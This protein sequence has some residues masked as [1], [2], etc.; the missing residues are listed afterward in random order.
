MADMNKEQQL[1]VKINEPSSYI[2]SQPVLNDDITKT[3]QVPAPS[4]LDSILQEQPVEK[5]EKKKKKKKKGKTGRQKE[6]E[7]LTKE[8]KEIFESPDKLNV[9][10]ERIH[11]L[12]LGQKK[13]LL[14][15]CQLLDKYNYGSLPYEQFRLIIRDRL[16]KLSTEDFFILTK[17]FE[18]G[19]TSIDY[20]AILDE[21]LGN[22]ILRHVTQLPVPLPTEIVLEK[23]SS[24]ESKSIFNEP[25]QVAQPKYVTL[26]LRLITFDA[27]NAYPGHVHITVPDHTS[28]YAL[29]KM[30]IDKTDLATRSISIFREK[31][32]SRHGLLDPMDTLEHHQLTGA[33]IDGTHK[34]LF[35]TYTLYY[36]YSPMELRSDCPILKCDYYMK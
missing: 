12:L 10:C 19:G 26:H 34:Q 6:I 4:F 25:L 30:V 1:Q 35:P 16:P 7:R 33:C 32:R 28:V 11:S 2:V 18:V 8:T 14:G 13:F 3:D 31:I 27:Y 17:L 36:D 21:E 9:V 29:S 24:K 15:A 20:R 22:G 5:D 23:K